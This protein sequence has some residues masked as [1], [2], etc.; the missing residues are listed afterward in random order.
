MK[1]LAL[2]IR[3]Y[4]EL[5]NQKHL[6]LIRYKLKPYAAHISLVGG[7]VVTRNLYHSQCHL[8]SDRTAFRCEHLSDVNIS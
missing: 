2:T 4:L 7:G 3:T 1:E 8:Y 5:L 6:E